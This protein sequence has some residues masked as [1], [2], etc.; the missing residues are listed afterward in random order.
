MEQLKARKGIKTTIREMNLGE[1]E[2]F[3]RSN[4]S[5]IRN[6]ICTLRIEYPERDYSLNVIDNGIEVICLS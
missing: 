5:T 3:P 1:K 2:V 6:T 4:Y